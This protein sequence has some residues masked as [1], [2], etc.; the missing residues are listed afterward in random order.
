MLLNKS[1]QNSLNAITLASLLITTPACTNLK[2][3]AESSQKTLIKE[4]LYFGLSKPGG[5]TVSEV[6]WQQFLNR[7]ITPRFKDGL[8]V[9]DAN[10]QYLNSSGVLVKEK[11]KVIVVI[12]ENSSTKN[13]MVKDTISNYKQ[14]FQQEAVLRVTSNVKVSF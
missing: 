6:E 12:Y 2:T 11:S 1:F 14:T 5:K 7:V 8:T 4:E 9:I 10:G 3:R 13:K